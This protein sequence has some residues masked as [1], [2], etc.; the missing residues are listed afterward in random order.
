MTEETHW[1]QHL[2][3]NWPVVSGALIACSTLF[4]WGKKKTSTL[5]RLDRDV[6]KLKPGETIVTNK[7]LDSNLS[8]CKKEVTGEMSKFF[9]SNMGEIK[10]F[11][12]EV[13]DSFAEIKEDFKYL[14]DRIDHLSERKK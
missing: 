3:D 9:E 1:L 5:A 7:D 4:A 11:S 10:T 8:E 6:P 13:R 12:D 14:R 2:K